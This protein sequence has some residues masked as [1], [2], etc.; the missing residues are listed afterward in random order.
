MG[1]GNQ[2]HVAYPY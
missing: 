1:V 2:S